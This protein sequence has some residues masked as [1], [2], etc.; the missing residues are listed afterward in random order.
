MGQ[1]LTFKVMDGNIQMRALTSQ[2]FAVCYWDQSNFWC[3]SFFPSSLKIKRIRIYKLLL[4]G[5]GWWE[6]QC[7]SA[8]CFSVPVCHQWTE[9]VPG[10]VL[11]GWVH[12]PTCWKG[13]GFLAWPICVP[14][15][16]LATCH[17]GCSSC[18]C[19]TSRQ[20][21]SQGRTGG[22]RSGYGFGLFD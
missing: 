9:L 22:L 6:C 4:P 19:Y 7:L 12:L 8:D 11:G 18:Y 5:G 14:G 16:F 17:N 3:F 10:F 15:C 20:E 2:A 21:W 1:N 13:Q